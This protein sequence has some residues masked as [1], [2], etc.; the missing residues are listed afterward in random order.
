MTTKNTLREQAENLLADAYKYYGSY[1]LANKVIRDL[2]RESQVNF[3]SSAFQFYPEGI[4]KDSS[5][6]EMEAA[7]MVF[8]TTKGE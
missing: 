2:L 8:S 7:G 6:A 1:K 3:E 5:I 4:T